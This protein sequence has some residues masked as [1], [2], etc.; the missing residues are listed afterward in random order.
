MPRL[1]TLAASLVG[2]LLTSPVPAQV[3]YYTLKSDLKDS[4]GTNHGVFEG[5]GGSNSSATFVTDPQFGSVLSFDGFDDRI[6]LGNVHTLQGSSWSISF[7]INT[8]EATAIGLLGKNDGGASFNIGERVMEITGAGSW[9]GLGANKETGNFAV[10]GHSMSGAAAKR[11]NCSVDVE[12]NDGAWHMLTAVHDKNVSVTDMTFYIDSKLASSVTGTF[13]NNRLDVGG[14][15]LG[16]SNL[17]GNKSDYMLGKMAE[18]HFYSKAIKAIDVLVLYLSARVNKQFV[19]DTPVISV[20]NGG[21]QKYRL[22]AG[23]CLANK[24]YW[25]FGSITG[26]KPGTGI[27]G[28]N[29]PLNAD[30]Y[31]TL[32]M[33]LTNTGVYTKFRGVLDSKGVATASFNV[34]AAQAIPIGVKLHHAFLVYDNSGVVLM[35]SN[36]IQIE[37]IK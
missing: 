11:T 36:A 23:E 26:D 15:Y 3:A 22:G 31:T 19:E 5:V 21:S 10:N 30:P 20:S 4:V 33:G 34:P 18:V 32:V 6:N 25:I 9:G 2:L 13:T 37:F 14:F 35:A 24:N 16:F 1:N 28:F 8:T 17:S 29:L 7:W 12:L 27:G